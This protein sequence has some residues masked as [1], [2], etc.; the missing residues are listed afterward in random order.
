MERAVTLDSNITDLNYTFQWFHNGVLVEG[1]TESTYLIDELGE[2]GEYYVIATSA[3]PY[4]GCSSE[5]SEPITIG[6][7]G[8]AAII[9][10]LPTNAFYDQQDIIV[11]VDGYG[12]YLYQLDNGP[13]QNT[14]HFVNFSSGAHTIT[15]YDVLP[16]DG[17]VDDDNNCRTVTRYNVSVVNYPHYF[18]PNGDGYHD[19][20]NI[21]GLNAYHNAELFIFDRY[22]KL[23]K[24]LNPIGDGWDGTYNGTPSSCYR[25]LVQSSV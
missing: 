3:A 5:P 23:L 20:W 6:L 19:T 14:G 8:P 13:L 21:T 24:Q 2:E 11:T 12:E 22:G 7:S 9:E 18:T 4:F 17:D 10:I 15:V 25:L 16:V 1:A